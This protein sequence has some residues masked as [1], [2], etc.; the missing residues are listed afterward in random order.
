MKL[1]DDEIR[2]QNWFNEVSSII[3]EGLFK[4][5]QSVCLSV[6]PLKILSGI[7][8]KFQVYSKFKVLY[9]LIKVFSI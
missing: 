5:N 8:T 6:C 7:S 1:L 9:K 2:V 3:L 4:T